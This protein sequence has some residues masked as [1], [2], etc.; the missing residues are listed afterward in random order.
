MQDDGNSG[1]MINAINVLQRP[2]IPHFADRGRVAY[3]RMRMPDNVSID[4]SQGIV[5]EPLQEQH[6]GNDQNR[7]VPSQDRGNA[8]GGEK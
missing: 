4:V 6:P 1:D 7:L 3:H 8:D 2:P 5:V